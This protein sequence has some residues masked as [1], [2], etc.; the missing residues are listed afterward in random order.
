MVYLLSRCLDTLTMK[1]TDL[2]SANPQ[3][4]PMK[5]NACG[6]VSFKDEGRDYL[7]VCGGIGM[8]ASANE[9]EAIYI[10]RKDDPNYGWT[11]ESHIF[12]L[13]NSMKL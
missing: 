8:L 6:M 9:P 11:N 2:P 4:S 3:K 1:W 12:E 5:K 13:S 7:F 10:P